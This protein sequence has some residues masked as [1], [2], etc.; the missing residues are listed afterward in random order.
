MIETKW[1]VTPVVV[2]KRSRIACRRSAYCCV[3][4]EAHFGHSFEGLWMI[5]CIATGVP[6]VLDHRTRVVMSERY[7]TDN[8]IAFAN[9]DVKFIE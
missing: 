3:E 5:V 8:V 6:S 7:K 1:F 4:G 9:V 2:D